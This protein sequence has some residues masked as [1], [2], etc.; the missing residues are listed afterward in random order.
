[1]GRSAGVRQG[2]RPVLLA[3]SCTGVS[4]S[5]DETKRNHCYC[6]YF[7]YKAYLRG[8]L[9][10]RHKTRQWFGFSASIPLFLCDAALGSWKMLNPRLRWRHQALG[11]QKVLF[12]LGHLDFSLAFLC[13]Q[14]EMLARCMGCQDTAPCASLAGVVGAA[15]PGAVRQASPEHNPAQELYQTLLVLDRLVLVTSSVTQTDTTSAQS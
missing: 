7:I 6:I 4:F 9:F 11:E 14:P 13:P 5:V 12:H 2:T 1:M 3:A 10:M 8:S 15:A